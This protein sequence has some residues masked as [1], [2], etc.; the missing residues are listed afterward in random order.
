[1]VYGAPRA[2][3]YRDVGWEVSAK[4]VA[5]L[6]LTHGMQG[7]SLRGFIPIITITR[8]PGHTVPDLVGRFD[9]DGLN[10]V[11][12]SDISYLATGQDWAV[13]LCAP[14]WA[15]RRVIGY[16][17]SASLHTDLVEAAQR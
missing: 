1:M 14:W 15:P 9:Q 8:E 11:W 3:A 16:V 7:I 4:S 13:S 10:L 2:T 5:E 6:M 17:F 12:T